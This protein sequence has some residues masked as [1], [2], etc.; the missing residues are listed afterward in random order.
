MSDLGIIRRVDDLGRIV[1]PRDIRRKFG[2][3]EGTPIVIDT[4]SEGIMMRKYYPENELSDMV[5]D[6]LK[7][8]EDMCTYLS[9]EKAM[10]IKHY[11]QDI[12]NLLKQ[13][14]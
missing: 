4:S 3:R 12:Q 6:L 9:P 11:L 1:L 13:V 7:N 10:D 8:I 2:I 14:E 5:K